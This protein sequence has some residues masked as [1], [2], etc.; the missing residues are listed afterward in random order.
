MLESSAME[1]KLE[2]LFDGKQDHESA[3]PWQPGGP[4]VS[5]RAS[6]TASQLGKGGDCPALLCSAQ[7]DFWDRFQTRS[8]TSPQRS[9]A[10]STS[11]LINNVHIF[12]LLSIC[13]V[14]AVNFESS[15]DVDLVLLNCVQTSKPHY[16][17][18]AHYVSLS[19]ILT[20][21]LACL[22]LG[23]REKLLKI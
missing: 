2:I 6:G 9:G 16:T 15:A 19:M 10:A 3:V 4:G 17:N 21:P 18:A 12:D 1:R 22:L 20:L 8:F 7:R 23:K 14:V 5:W 13:C 11:C